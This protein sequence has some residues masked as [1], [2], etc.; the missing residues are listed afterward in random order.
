M[1]HKIIKIKNV[2]RLKDVKFGKSNW[3]GIFEKVNVFYADN[4]SGK[5]TLTQVLKST[6]SL[7]AA[8]KLLQKKSFDTEED[9]EITYFDD[10]N[11]QYNYSKGRWNGYIS[12]I[13]VFDSYYV[14]NNVYIITL[15][16]Y[17]EPGSYYDIVVGKEAIRTFKEIQNNIQ[18]RKKEKTKR[19]N[20]KRKLKT[21]TDETEADK[22]NSIIEQ[23][24]KNS[25]S[26]NKLIRDLE[27]K[28]K[29]EAEEFGQTYLDA[30]NYYLKR[31]GTDLKLTGLNKKARRF[32]YY[33]SIKDY[34][35]RSDTQSVSLRHTLSEGE[36]NCLAFAFFL[37]Q[38][39]LRKDIESRIVVFDDPISSLDYNRRHITLNILTEYAKKCKQFFL[40]SH[41]AHFINDFKKKNNEALVLKIAKAKDSSQIIPFNVEQECM[42]GIFKDIFVLKDFV[43]N[44]ELSQYNLRDVARCIRPVLEGVFRIKFYMHIKQNEWLGDFISNIRNAKSGEP[45]FRLTNCLTDL[46]ILNDYSKTYHHSNPEYMSEEI[47]GS[48]L[49]GYCKLL[50]DVIERI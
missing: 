2:G 25:E 24:K 31:L 29:K 20:L 28:Q 43:E 35:L 13:N 48:E 15:G 32:V 5:T 12:T 23:S 50:F 49:Q 34:E 6:T 19:S 33:I 3:N 18:L 11:R 10:K 16:N 27:K 39:H 37:A 41:D 17:D 42:T 44:G 45:F 1:I 26:I 36:K 8:Q 47:V 38:L 46:E 9:I 30:I 40:L 7:N 22:I 14:E 4:G 21:I